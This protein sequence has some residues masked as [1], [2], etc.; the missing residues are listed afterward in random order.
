MVQSEERNNHDTLPVNLREAIGHSKCVPS[1]L[2]TLFFQ[3]SSFASFDSL[4]S[5]SIFNE[6]RR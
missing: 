3:K 6:S 2:L 4:F 5:G 1:S